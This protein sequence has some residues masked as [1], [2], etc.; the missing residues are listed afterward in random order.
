MAVLGT[1]FFGVVGQQLALSVWVDAAKWTA[2]LTLGL[3]GLAFVL[4][5]LLPR[6]ARAH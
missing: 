5:F 2:L 4:G 6:K 3:T 1:V